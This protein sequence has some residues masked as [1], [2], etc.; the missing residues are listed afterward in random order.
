MELLYY[1]QNKHNKYTFNLNYCIIT[2]VKV[3]QLNQLDMT[4]NIFFHN[5]MFKF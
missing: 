4:S 5:K 3:K 1:R 2:E